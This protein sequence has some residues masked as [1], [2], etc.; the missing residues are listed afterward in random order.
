MVMERGRGVKVLLLCGAVAAAACKNEVPLPAKAV[1]LNRLGAL[2]LAAGDLPTAEARLAVAIEYSPKFTEAWVNLGLVELRKGDVK[3]ARKDVARARSLNPDLPAPHHAMGLVEEKEARTKKA[4]ADYRAALAVDPGFAPARANLGRLLF[5]GG[6]YDEAREQF[7][8]LTEVAPEAVEG[9]LGLAESLLRLGREAD[10]DVV[11]W[12]ARL[13]FGDRPE[14]VLLVARQLLRRG[15]PAAA[16]TLLEPLTATGDAPRRSSAWAWLA[17]ARMASGR[18]DEAAKAAEESLAA[19][20]ED[21]V[22]RFVVSKLVAT[23][24]LVDGVDR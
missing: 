4:I 2:A 21:P 7:L 10:S 23:H 9:W 3:A 11:V 17:V 12:R 22:A 15:A 16:E 24:P 8:R 13:R 6:R 18:T 14:L 1:E 5:D 19:S 20:P